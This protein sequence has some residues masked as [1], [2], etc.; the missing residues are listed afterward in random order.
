MMNLLTRIGWDARLLLAAPRPDAASVLE[1]SAGELVDYLLFA[2][3]MPLPAAVSGTSGFAEQFAK[4]GP[5]D[6]R[7]RSLRE[8]DLRGCS[9]TPAAT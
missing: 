3:E 8:L 2:D 7:G 1:R 6:R 4:G 9:A 5:A